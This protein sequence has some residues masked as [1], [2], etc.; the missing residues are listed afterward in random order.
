MFKLSKK[1]VYGLL[2]L[3]HLIELEDGE[4]ATVREMSEIY[5]ISQPLLAKICQNL[6]KHKLIQ[7]VQGARGGY[8]LQVPAGD[9]SIAQVVE[10]LEGPITLVD[11]ADHQHVCKRVDQCRL[12][13]GFLSLQKHF[14]DY[15]GQ[16]SLAD[17][18]SL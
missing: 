6:S 1:T 18:Q 8:Q 4:S 9:I 5:N 16:V 7:S 2:A 11:C 10:A 17:M 13:P 3:Q 12:K 15:L 14:R